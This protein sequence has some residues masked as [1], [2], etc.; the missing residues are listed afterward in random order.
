MAEDQ[1]KDKE[2]LAK[3]W[4]AYEAQEREFNQA[5]TKI[6]T[7]EDQH[8]DRDRIIDTL[9][10]VV[11]SRDKELRDLEIR[12]TTLNDEKSRTEPVIDELK[13]SLR[14]EKER[15]AKLFAITE[16][17]EEELEEARSQ[18]EARDHWFNRN[19]GKLEALDEAIRERSRM[20]AS[21]LPSETRKA[22]S[23]GKPLFREVPQSPP[24]R[25]ESI[26]SLTGI[27]SVDGE[28]ADRLYTSGYYSREQIKGVPPADLSRVEG[29]SPT[30]AR[31]ITE[32][33]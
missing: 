18:L 10:K 20:V 32:E 24:P 30:L 15:Y 29:I 21:A 33:A 22:P 9:K 1:S 11:E 14:S 3:L 2:R 7:L 5:L 26:A 13:T 12:H 31:K 19:V 28:V 4:D 25:E 16:E 8:R 17:L 23:S 27:P 6:K